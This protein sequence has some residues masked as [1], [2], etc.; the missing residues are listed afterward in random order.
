MSG[1]ICGGVISQSL[2]DSN[3]GAYMMSYYLPDKQFERY[4]KA[5]ENGDNK[6]AN[7]IFDKYSYSAI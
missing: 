4:K 1:A 2:F 5:K 3:P 6:K 7:Q